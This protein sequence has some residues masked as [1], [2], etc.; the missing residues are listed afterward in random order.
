M[1]GEKIEEIEDEVDP[2]QMA[3]PDEIFQDLEAVS[4]K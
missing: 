2:E 1:A 3:D 4:D